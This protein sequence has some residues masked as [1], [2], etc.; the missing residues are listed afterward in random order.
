MPW[1]DPKRVDPRRSVL[2]H[3]RRYVAAQM[4]QF[5]TP[6]EELVKRAEIKLESPAPDTAGPA[7][8]QARGGCG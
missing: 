2:D 4:H 7:G 1:K 6:P 5:R 3:L 8:E